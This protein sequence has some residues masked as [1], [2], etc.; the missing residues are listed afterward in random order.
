MKVGDVFYK[1]CTVTEMSKRVQG[2]VSEYE[3]ENFDI[4]KHNVEIVSNI[5]EY[6]RNRENELYNLMISLTDGTEMYKEIR[7][8]HIELLNILEDLGIEI[9]Q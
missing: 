6:L 9:S 3:E 5:Q 1:K 7:A 2:A 4:E 8:K